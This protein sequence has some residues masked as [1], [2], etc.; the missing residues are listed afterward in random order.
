MMAGAI[1]LVMVV[2]HFLLFGLADINIWFVIADRTLHYVDPIFYAPW[3]LLFQRHGTL[4]WR[5]LPEDA[6]LS[7]ALPDLG[8]GARRGGE[9][10]PLPVP[11]RQQARLPARCWSTALGSSAGFVVLYA[12]VIAIDRWLGRRSLRAA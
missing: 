5:D 7:A 6:G 3:W 1:V 10:V 11:R 2:V 4:A 8:D 12:L 9:R